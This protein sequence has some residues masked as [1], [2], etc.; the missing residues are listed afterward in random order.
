MDFNPKSAT[1]TETD[2]EEDKLLEAMKTRLGAL[3][4]L[5]LVT[6]H[7]LINGFFSL[8]KSSLETSGGKLTH[9]AANKCQSAVAV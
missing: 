4:L 1:N 3:P 2:R 8:Q 5:C 6:I 7:N 9:K